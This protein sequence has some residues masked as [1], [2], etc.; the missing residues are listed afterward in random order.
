MPDIYEYWIHNVYIHAYDKQLFD[1]T[2]AAH[3]FFRQTK[4]ELKAA[5]SMVAVI[6]ITRCFPSKY[7]TTPFIS[8][9]QKPSRYHQSTAI[10]LLLLCRI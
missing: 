1:K 7:V 8:T 5:E 6:L 9:V 10:W 2:I 4:T 3:T